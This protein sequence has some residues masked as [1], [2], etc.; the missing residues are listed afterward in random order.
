[1]KDD[2]ETD[3]KQS[4]AELKARKRLDETKEKLKIQIQTL[5][6]NNYSMTRIARI[7]GIRRTTLYYLMWG[8]DGRRSQIKS[9]SIAVASD[10]PLHDDQPEYREVA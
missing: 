8:R 10:L 4:A 9:R 5:L 2:V 6:D 1:M 7:T 3:I